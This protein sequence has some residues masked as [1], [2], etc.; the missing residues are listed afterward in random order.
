MN[1]HVFDQ[2]AGRIDEIMTASPFPEDVFHSLNTL[3]WVLKIAPDADMALQI[4]ALGHDI[5]HG[6]PDRSVHPANYQTYDEYK[7]AHAINSAQI[8]REILEECGAAPETVEDVT[9]LVANHETGGD[10]RQET[11]KNADVLSFFSVALPLFNDRRG[12]EITK[13]RCVWGFKKLPLEL[14]A[15]V[16]EIEYPDE[17]LKHLLTESIGL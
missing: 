7:Q 2:V 13:K 6:L 12:P 15:M 10:P 5:E 11:L 3:E 17:D 8:L 16:R 9:R 1:F 14:Q 4:A